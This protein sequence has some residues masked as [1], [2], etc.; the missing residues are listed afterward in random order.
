MAASPREDP[1][2]DIAAIVAHSL[3]N[4]MS[5][6]AGAAHILERYGH[7][8]APDERLDVIRRM[9]KHADHVMGILGDVARGLHPD[10]YD[11]LDHVADRELSAEG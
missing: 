11:A 7:T 5:V 3:L 10:V 8:L 9:A 6:V 4:S 2:L 1:A